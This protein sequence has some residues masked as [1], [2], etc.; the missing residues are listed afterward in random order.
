MQRFSYEAVDSKGRKVVDT[1]EAWDKDLMFNDS[2]GSSLKDKTGFFQIH[3]D[4]AYF[5][6]IFSDRRPD[7]FPKVS[8]TR[9]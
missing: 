4:A 3:F 7:L 1:V 6:E 2:V 5:D 8:G 9:S